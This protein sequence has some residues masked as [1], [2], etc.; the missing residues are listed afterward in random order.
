MKFLNKSVKMIR[1]TNHV[2]KINLNQKMKDKFKMTNNFIGMNKKFLKPIL[3]HKKIIIRLKK[4]QSIMLSNKKK[5]MEEMNLKNPTFSISSHIGK[6]WRKELINMKNKRKY[7]LRKMN[8]NL[9]KMMKNRINM[10]L[11]QKK[12]MSLHSLANLRK[13]ENN[14]SKNRKMNLDNLKNASPLNH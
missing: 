8:N 2:K 7:K 14:N 11:K 1:T 9:K 12:L 6:K 4:K 3:Y 5:A 10:H 13:K